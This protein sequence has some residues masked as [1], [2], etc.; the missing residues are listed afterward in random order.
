L[1]PADARAV[2][3]WFYN[4]QPIAEGETVTVDSYG[5][6]ISLNLKAPKQPTIKIPCPASGSEAFWNSPTGGLDK[7]LSISFACPQGTTAT[8]I[9]PWRSTLLESELPLHD[10]WENVALDLTYNGVNYGIFT[11]SLNTVVG[12][13]DSEKERETRPRDEPDSYVAFRDGAKRSLSG[14]NHYKLWL[15]GGYHFGARGS[16]V[17][18]ETGFWGNP[19][20]SSAGPLAPYEALDRP[21]DI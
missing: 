2:T 13:V 19:L 6:K 1:L 10:R 15:T 3:Q 17:T 12:D 20:M 14:P 11:G 9:L 4:H 21:E 16:R 8:P 5:P 18:D 7:T